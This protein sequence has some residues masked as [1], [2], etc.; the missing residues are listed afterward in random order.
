MNKSKSDCPV[1]FENYNNETKEPFCLSCGHTICQTCLNDLNK[2]YAEKLHGIKCPFCNQENVTAVKNFA[3][4]EEFETLGTMS[5]VK[6]T[7][8][9]LEEKK[10]E[11]L[12]Q[13]G[14]YKLKAKH[15]GKYLEIKK[16]SKDS[17]AVLVQNEKSDKPHQTFKFIQHGDYYVI[18]VQ[19]TKMVL[20][21]PVKE[22]EE[23]LAHIVQDNFEGEDHQ[24]WKLEKQ[25]GGLFYIVNKK[26]DFCLDVDLKLKDNNAPVVQ[27]GRKPVE[28][29]ENQLFYFELANAS[30]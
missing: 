5:Y 27:F 29:A 8:A 13:A 28:K 4:I 1:C 3:L 7:R 15:S 25:E 2:K 20:E 23:P 10:K 17:R 12:I 26:S 24:F 16:G 14:F 19:H 21:I 6:N 22:V 9:R 18:S 30:N 11:P